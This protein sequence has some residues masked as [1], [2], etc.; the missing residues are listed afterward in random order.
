MT[1]DHR[2]G[3]YLETDGASIYFELAGKRGGPPLLVLH[4]G[5]GNLEDFNGILPDLDGGFRIIGIDSR[6]HGK[7]TFGPGPL[8]YAQLQSDVERVLA[9]VGVDTTSIIGFSDGGTTAYRLASMSSL[10][11]ERMVTIGASWH[12][13]NLEPARDMCLRIS[14]TSWRK[15]FPADHDDYQRLNP[16]PDIDRL[17]RAVVNLWLDPSPAG[18]PNE[19]VADISCPLLMVRGDEDHLL[20]LEAVCELSALVR[21]SKLLNVPFAGHAAFQE[22]KDI[23][24]ICLNQFLDPS[25]VE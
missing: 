1:F 23:F 16:E 8:T 24:R 18:H 15:K 6:G 2:S 25:P 7:S 13:K 10:R 12:A 14:G 11:V 21:K 3:D 19:A 9:H 17:A 20:P 5:F 22:Q 4:G